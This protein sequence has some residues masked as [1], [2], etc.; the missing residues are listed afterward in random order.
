MMPDPLHMLH[1]TLFHP[2]LNILDL[3]ARQ[4]AKVQ[5]TEKSKPLTSVSNIMQSDGRRIEAT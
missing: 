1:R 3:V 4:M 5:A 2:I